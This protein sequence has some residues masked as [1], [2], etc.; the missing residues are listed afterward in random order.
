M[1]IPGGPQP[2]LVVLLDP[3]GRPCGTADKATVHGERT[4][5]H[6]AFSC[7]VFDRAG[8]LLVTR[9]ATGKRTWP[10]AWTNSC[11]GHPGPGELPEEAVRRRLREELGLTPL[12]L[13]LALPDFSY[14]AS[15]DG[16]EEHELC[17][18]F[19]ARVDAEPVP[20]PLEVAE[21]VWST[22]GRFVR[23]EDLSP[24]ALLQ[25]A[26]LAPHVA[27]FLSGAETGVRRQSA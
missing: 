6:L 22:F 1:T 19:L 13:R 17:P 24:W 5:Y 3:L 23:R 10:G 14:R 11:C 4:P 8:R 26:Q 12:A 25:A 21:C 2:E 9:R 16:V 27:D 7:Y 18:V 15:L 20:N